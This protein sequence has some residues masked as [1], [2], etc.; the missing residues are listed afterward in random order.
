M[1]GTLP[2]VLFSNIL[3]YWVDIKSL[4]HLD[5]AYCNHVDRLAFASLLAS[6]EFTFRSLVSFDS[7]KLIAWLSKKEV[8]ASSIKLSTASE[9]LPDYL[10]NWGSFINSVITGM[11][12]AGEIS[13][14]ILFIAIHCKN[15]QV[16]RCSHFRLN[17]AFK[18]LL[19]CNPN[20]SEI[21]LSHLCGDGASVFDN[22]PLSKLSTLSIS[23]STRYSNYSLPITS[24]SNTLQK[25]RLD[26]RVDAELIVKTVRLTPAL[27]SLSLEDVQLSDEMLIEIC[28]ILPTLLHL[29]VSNNHLLSSNGVLAMCK[30]LTQ[31]RSINLQNCPYVLDSTMRN[32]ATYCG[33]T[34]E[35][36]Y[37]EI[38]NANHASVVEELEYFSRR[39]VK[40]H[41]LSIMCNRSVLCPAG[42]TFA[43][44]QGL[45]SLRLLIIETEAVIC[46]SSRRFLQVTHPLLRIVVE[47]VWHDK[48]PFNAL[49]MAI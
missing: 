29:D 39:C 43:L 42:G 2:T 15:L 13:H 17:P 8:K 38:K 10:R 44:L 37:M 4:V 35:V 23:R 19:W 31:L 5:S 6:K 47:G 21:W 14:V 16:I 9:L 12:S 41:T 36:V 34:L 22:I 7:S 49:H 46:V 20:I 3:G 32:L 1:I 45:P 28:S 33:E 25:L 24:V 11:P 18:E 40:L 48:Y 26:G 27:K 30:S